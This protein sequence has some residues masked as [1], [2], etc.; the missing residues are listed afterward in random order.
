MGVNNDEGAE[1]MLT[2]RGHLTPFRLNACKFQAKQVGA[3][4]VL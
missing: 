4:N 1:A 2:D 3:V